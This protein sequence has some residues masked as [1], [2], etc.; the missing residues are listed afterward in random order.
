MSQFKPILLLTHK[1]ERQY[2]EERQDKIDLSLGVT[3]GSK[4]KIW[5]KYDLQI[6]PISCADLIGKGLG[7]G[8]GNFLQRAHI[9]F[10]PK[11]AGDVAPFQGLLIQAVHAPFGLGFPFGV[12][13]SNQEFECSDC[14]HFHFS[15]AIGCISRPDFSPLVK[16]RM[17]ISFI[18]L[19]NA[20]VLM[21]SLLNIVCCHC[22]RVLINN[23]NFIYIII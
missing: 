23:V 9:Q 5:E 12:F 7:D 22:I 11:T 13:D 19:S 10:K 8:S 17:I 16:H 3:E 6:S 20:S 21:Y 18:V 1:N 2:L 14:Q 15:R 4:V